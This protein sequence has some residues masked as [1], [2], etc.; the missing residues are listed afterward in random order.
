M[1]S[2]S[3]CIPALGKATSLP[4]GQLRSILRHF[5]ATPARLIGP[6]PSVIILAAGV[7]CPAVITADFLCAECIAAA[8]LII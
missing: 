3:A 2:I 1:T 4:G 5:D 7:A 8:S 6:D